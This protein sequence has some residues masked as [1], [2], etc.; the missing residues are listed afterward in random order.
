MKITLYELLRVAPAASKEEIDLA[1]VSLVQQHPWA[2]A[3]ERG[4]LIRA[5]HSLLSRPESKQA[6]DQMLAG[7]KWPCPASSCLV[8]PLL[9]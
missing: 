2:A 8:W 7:G 4:R 5:A 6:Y 9:P 1:F 3:G